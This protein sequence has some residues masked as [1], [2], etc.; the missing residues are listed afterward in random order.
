[1][2]VARLQC[3]ARTGPLRG[4]NECLQNSCVTTCSNCTV[5]QLRK[6]GGGQ[7]LQSDNVQ[8]AALLAQTLDGT[9]KQVT[10]AAQQ[11]CQWSPGLLREVLTTCC[12][13]CTAFTP[14]TSDSYQKHY[15]ST[16]LR[17]RLPWQQIAASPNRYSL[18][19]VLQLPKSGPDCR[20][21]P[22]S[23]CRLLFITSLP[24]H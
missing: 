18:T 11:S 24:E 12:C 3:P 14:I 2:T 22:S 19:A 21:Q 15:R 1:M 7:C 8:P 10:A 4:L 13:L 9:V 6:C 16:V 23:G 17:G 20:P 5:Q